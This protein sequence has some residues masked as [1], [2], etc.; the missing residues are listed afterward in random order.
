MYSC[1]LIL[2]ISIS[3]KEMAKGKKRREMA[4]EQGAEV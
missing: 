1:S 4:K 2:S 3:A